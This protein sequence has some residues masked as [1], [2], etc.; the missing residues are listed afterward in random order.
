MGDNLKNQ[1]TFFAPI[2]YLKNVADALEFF[3]KAFNIVDLR[4]WS[5]ETEV[6]M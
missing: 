3:K 6:F 2:L 1:S 4:R 5:K